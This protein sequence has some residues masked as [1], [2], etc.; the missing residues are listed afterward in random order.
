MFLA[1]EAAKEKTGQGLG[2]RRNLMVP[3]LIFK[4]GRAEEQ[5]LPFPFILKKTV[6]KNQGPLDYVSTY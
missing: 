2:T 6:R 4:A 1:N 3:K 5:P